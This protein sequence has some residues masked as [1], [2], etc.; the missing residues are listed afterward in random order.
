MDKQIIGIACHVSEILEN[1]TS[2][3]TLWMIPKQGF[4]IPHNANIRIHVRNNHNSQNR[5]KQMHLH[6][7]T[8]AYITAE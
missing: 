8:I 7:R 3:P 6:K 2:I 5:M 4:L 1:C